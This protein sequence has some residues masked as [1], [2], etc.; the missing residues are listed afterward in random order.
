MTR[1]VYRFLVLGL[2]LSA[3]TLPAMA[4]GWQT[5]SAAFPSTACQDGWASCITAGGTV[6]P[7]MLHDL[8]GRPIPSDG[9]L[10]WFDLK[11][12]A[13]FSPFVG[14]SAYSGQPGGT[15]PPPAPAPSPVA[16]AS[17]DTPSAQGREP[18][19]QDMSIRTGP[20]GGQG[21]SEPMGGMSGRPAA[22]S[23]AGSPTTTPAMA[24]NTQPTSGP[25]GAQTVSNTSQ[26]TSAPPVAATPITTVTPVSPPL[27]TPVAQLTTVQTTGD[28]TDLVSLEPAAMMGSLTTAQSKCLEGRL[29]TEAQQTTRAKIS[30]VMINNA[31]GKGDKSE[32]ER[33]VKRH[34]EDV[35]RSDPD[36]CYKYSL[37]LSKGGA[38][39]ATGVIRW[40]DYSLEN[41]AKWSGNTYKS[42]VFAL[43]RLKTEAANKLW[44]DAEATY[45]TEHTDENEAKSS[46]YRG[47]TKDYAREWLDYAKASAQD[48]KAAMQYCVSSA[49]TTS[50]CEG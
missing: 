46:R 27:P 31:D 4:G 8:S 21:T 5:F 42:R 22:Q 30:L 2:G 32:W 17:N 33:L 10:G 24:V 44:Q 6:G 20:S 18:A 15:V 43:G 36:L 16:V 47:M 39:R 38:G 50:F 25:T 35:D 19:G 3:L 7:G 41:K 40:A 29:A 13:S 14:L 12:T 28:C 1:T 37:Q 9:R 26:P 49:G 11:P 48:T 34:L 45:T 23:G